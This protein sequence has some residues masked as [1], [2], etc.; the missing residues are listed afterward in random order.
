LTKGPRE[1]RESVTTV[2]V[3]RTIDDYDATPRTA[4]DRGGRPRAAQPAQPLRP[5][6]QGRRR[7]GR[8]DAW[9]SRRAPGSGRR[10][11]PSGRSARPRPG[12]RADGASQPARAT[13][14]AESRRT[15]VRPRRRPTALI[16]YL[17]TSAL[18]KLIFDEPGSEL[19]VELWD[20]ADILVSSQLVY[21][22]AR[23]ALAAA[24]RGGRI[25]ESTHVGAVS[26]LEDLYSQ[27]RTVA[28]DEPLVRHAGD[29][30]A[31]HAL[32][33]YDAV[34]LAC[35]LQ[36]RGDDILLATWG[37]ALNAAAHATG[38]LFANETA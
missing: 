11:R 26:A 31:Q 3:A 22:E 6:R 25:G 7:G 35:A 16:V 37:T 34:H 2:D 18:V 38:R 32:R 8:H 33:G 4:E 28:I 23:A 27:L 14:T 9:P 13:S 21:P 15:R 5:A 30:A 10:G 24:A 1:R 29:L 12:S 36:L 20:R 19:A 17:D